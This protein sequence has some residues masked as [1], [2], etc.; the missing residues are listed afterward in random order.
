MG[1][2]LSRELPKAKDLKVGDCTGEA[3]PRHSSRPIPIR[4]VIEV[5]QVKNGDP[6]QVDVF[7][8]IGDG[9]TRSIQHVDG[10]TEVIIFPPYRAGYQA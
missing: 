6:G 7:F 10:D 1:K 9:T 2:E 8:V 3:Y 5:N 4:E